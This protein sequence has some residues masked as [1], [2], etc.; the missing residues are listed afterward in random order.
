MF[1]GIPYGAPTGGAARFRPPAKPAPWTGVRDALAFGAGCPQALTTSLLG[2]LT[3][4]VYA[5][6]LSSDDS[7]DR[8][9]EDC[10]VLNLWTPQVGDGGKRPVMVW[11]HGGFFTQG[12]ASSNLYDGCRLCARGG[13]VVV[14]VNH[15]LNVFGFLHLAE[16]DA[17]FEQ[18]GNVGMLDLTAALE[19][20]RDNIADFG[21][22]PANVTIFGES[23]GGAKVSTLLAMPAGEG[24]FHKAIIQSGASVKANGAAEATALAHLLLKELD[25][26]PERVGELQEVDP[27]VLLKASLAAEAKTG[28]LMLDGSFGSWAPLVDGVSLPHHPFD[29]AAPAESIRVPLMVGTMKDETIMVLAGSEGFATMGEEQ[30]RAMLAPIL[31]ARADEA[32]A[33]SKRLYPE[34]SPGYLMANLLTDFLA[35]T[36]ATLVAERKAQGGAAPAFLYV[37]TWET[38]VAGGVL[39]SMHALDI[40]LVFDN[41]S[42]ARSMVGE[43]PE[44]MELAE[45]MSTTWLAFARNGAPDNPR[46][47]HWPA[48]D[49]ERRATMVF[50]R[51]C[52][53]VDDYAGEACRFWSAYRR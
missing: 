47:P 50:D 34:E 35:R 22:D 33:L 29:P 13:V 3:R 8:Q 46:I 19:W 16:I 25:L 49:V 26:P 17:R 40:P 1:K 30:M 48:Y 20:V 15:R 18:S 36:P 45:K 7:W 32:I 39:R 44:P 37:V 9:G 5:D 38:P 23:G 53:S 12:S 31:G 28:K 51:T 27:L 6:V 11:F 10:L 24:L 41:V 2:P 52:E 43:G 4:E 42:R 21:G 14:T